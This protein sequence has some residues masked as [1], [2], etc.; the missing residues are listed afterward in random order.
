[1]SEGHSVRMFSFG[2]PDPG[3]EFPLKLAWSAAHVSLKLFPVC[4]RGVGGE[5]REVRTCWCMP[6]L[7][8]M[9]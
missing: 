7:L 2:P 4:N 8:C 9:V 5:G 6:Y 1:M 3:T